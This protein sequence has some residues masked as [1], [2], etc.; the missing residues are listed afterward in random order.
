T[1]TAIKGAP[2]GDD[3]HQLW[4]YPDYPNRM[5]LASEQGAVV[6][7]DGAATWSSWY[8]QPTAEMYHVATDFRFPYWVMGSQPESGSAAVPSRSN[9]AEISNRDWVP[10][11]AGGE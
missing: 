11:C 3:Y 9:H 7:E 10:A 5:I 2:D 8:N 1:W 6:T 4:I